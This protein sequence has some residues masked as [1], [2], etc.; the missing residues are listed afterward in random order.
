MIPRPTLPGVDTEL[1]RST[2][3]SQSLTATLHR[4]G[5]QSSLAPLRPRLHSSPADS[6]RLRCDNDPQTC[7]L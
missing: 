5:R 4:H 1:T 3:R 7:R 2:D 6:A